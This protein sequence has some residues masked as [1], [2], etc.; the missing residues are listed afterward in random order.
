MKKFLMVFGACVAGTLVALVV[1][2][3]IQ[4]RRDQAVFRNAISVIGQPAS[5][6]ADSL[7]LPDFRTPAKRVMKSV[8]SVKT[9]GQ[10]VNWFGNESVQ[11]FGEGS[12]VIL[13]ENGFIVTNNHVIRDPQGAIAQIVNVILSDGKT[14]PAKV[15]G[16]DPRSDLAVLKVT[17]T[18]LV[19]IEPGS[20]KNLEIGQWVLA[21]GNPLGYSNTISVGVV[22]SMNRLVDLRRVGGMRGET[23]T[24]ALV[25]AIQT[26]A[27]INPGNSGG[28]LCDLSGRLV[29]IN[30]A[31]ASTSGGSVGI[32]F[33]I[34][35]DRV[36]RIAD[37]IIKYGHARYGVL[38]VQFNRRSGLMQMMPVRQEIERLVGSLPP[39]EG[40]LIMEVTPG[41]SAA[42]AGM[43]NYSVLQR[44]DN[45]AIRDTIDISQALADKMPGDKVKVN[46]WVRGQNK[47]VLLTL[48]DSTEI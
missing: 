47:E 42:K 28:A 23:P 24:D 15:V 35:V 45:V 29:G 18:G 39:A 22:S 17:A 8:V 7:A 4:L 46:F 31:I 34:P 2:D 32:G 9:A 41:G 13:S 1:H 38:G 27:A 40:V 25:N 16:A 33:A 43:E 26:D 14:V 44:I 3:Q 37:D 11:N 36:R 19:P 10:V 6:P 21:A 12:G 30:S 5:N 20:S 48:Q